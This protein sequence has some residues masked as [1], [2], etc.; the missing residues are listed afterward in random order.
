MPFVSGFLAALVIAAAVAWME[1]FRASWNCD[2]Q[3][4]ALSPTE[5]P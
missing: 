5:F 1:T 2:A 3:L 4:V